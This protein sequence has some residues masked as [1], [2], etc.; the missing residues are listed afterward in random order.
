MIPWQDDRIVESIANAIKTADN[1]AK[2]E[3]GLAAV[4]ALSME[5][6]TA[7]TPFLVAV[8]PTILTA[9][10]DKVCSC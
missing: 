6:G 9:Y 8:L 2:G 1:P 5:I 3:T 4:T 7:V 10:A